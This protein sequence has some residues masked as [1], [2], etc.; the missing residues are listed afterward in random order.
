MPT[1]SYGLFYV[2]GSFLEKLRIYFEKMNQGEANEN[3]MGTKTSERKESER[4]N[5]AEARTR[6]NKA[7][8]DVS[9]TKPAK[10]RTRPTLEEMKEA[11]EK[12]A[13]LEE[14]IASQ[15]R[16]MD[17]HQGKMMMLEEVIRQ[18]C[19][20]IKENDDK[21][22]YDQLAKAAPDTQ[23]LWDRIENQLSSMIEKKAYDSGDD[24]SLAK[25]KH[26]FDA[27]CLQ[28]QEQGQCIKK[29]EEQFEDQL[30]RIEMMREMLDENSNQT[31]K[32]S[33]VRVILEDH[34][35]RLN[36][37]EDRMAIYE[38]QVE[39]RLAEQHQ[40]L[41]FTWL[42]LITTFVLCFAIVCSC[43]WFR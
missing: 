40:L 5:Q 20:V 33:S 23:T 15:K 10:K 30:A 41:I 18:Q 37:L 2:M 36:A 38:K 31:G 27:Q 25:I 3:K 1:R 17:E 39:K 26:Q 9:A 19:L 32:E 21:Y 6:E 8:D 4:K 43:C 7:N 24:T 29:H 22:T 13:S 42:G 14:Q 12:M 34:E 11:K 28:L 16:M 35:K